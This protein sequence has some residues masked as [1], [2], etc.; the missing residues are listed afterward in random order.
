MFFKMAL[1]N[2]IRHKRK[3]LISALTIGVGLMFYIAMDSLF[4]GIDNLLVESIVKFSDSSIVIYS[5]DYDQNRRAFPLDKGIRDF[6]GIKNTI[7]GIDG[8]EDLTYRTTF[9]GEIALSGRSKYVVVTVIDTEMDT[10]VFELKKYVV[11]NYLRGERDI[12]LGKVLAN[13]LGV[14]VGD[15][16]VLRAKTL[17]GDYNSLD[18]KIVGLIESPSTTINESGVFMA[19][20][21]ANRLLKLNDTKTSVHVKVS[22]GKGESIDSYLK[23]V[24]EVAN[25]IRSKLDG[26]SVYTIKDIYGDFIL[27]MEQKRATSFIISFL[28]LIIAGVGIANNILMSVYERIKEIGVLMAMGMKPGEIKKLF[29]LEGILT[30]VVGGFFGVILGFIGDLLMIYVG[31]DIPSLLKGV[32]ASDI[33]MPVWGV[34]YGVWNPRA[35]FEGFIFALIVSAFSSYFPSRYASKLKVVDCLKFV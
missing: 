7:K 9:L 5:K 32:N 28:I 24:E 11:G 21:G 15:N 31:Y 30:G 29:L 2:I 8:V 14:S 20:T 1:R 10:K 26:Y 25:N 23:R 16:V 27:L 4:M 17:Y 13:K 3:T 19:Y 6:E 12:V 33:G 22:W 35:F 18:F 34:I